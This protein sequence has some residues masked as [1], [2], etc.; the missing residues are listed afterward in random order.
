MLL[1][2]IWAASTPVMPPAP[3]R[4]AVLAGAI[5]AAMSSSALMP[6]AKG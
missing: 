2:G 3:S 4:C 1:N 6:A 5:K